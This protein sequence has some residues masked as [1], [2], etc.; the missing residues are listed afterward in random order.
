MGT[1]SGHI[2][3]VNGTD[4]KILPRYPIQV[5]GRIKSEIQLMKMDSMEKQYHLVVHASDGNVYNIDG[6]TLCYDKIEIG[7][8]SMSA[9][10][11]DDLTQDG[12]LD[13]LVL[14]TRGKAYC[15]STKLKY[16]PS[17]VWTTNWYGASNV[18]TCNNDY[19]GIYVEKFSR[20]Y[21]DVR[22]SSF[23]VVFT[24]SDKRKPDEKNPPLYKVEIFLDGK[25][26]MVNNFTRAGIYVWN[27][28]SP[29]ERKLS[30][31]IVKMTNEKG[32]I[33]WDY[34][35]LSF[36]KHFAKTVKAKFQKKNFFSEFFFADKQFS[37]SGYSLCLFCFSPQLYSL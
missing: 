32:Q 11:S 15:I 13:L 23:P 22:G 3:A 25:H 7:E 34:Y 26:V 24:I 21:R 20:V 1:R 28:P 30:T 37:F 29:L 10:I 9:I 6:Q 4:G 16:D 2:Y 35:T 19:H 18:H 14:S 27:L 33:Y 17:V 36:N 12:H 8:D 31:I 5:G